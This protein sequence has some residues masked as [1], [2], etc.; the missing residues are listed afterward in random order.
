MFR[1]ERLDYPPDLEASHVEDELKFAF[2]CLDQRMSELLYFA[3][4]TETW[5]DEPGHAQ[6]FDANL[7]AK[8][9]CKVDSSKIW[10]DVFPTITGGSI[11]VMRVRLGRK[12]WVVLP[13]YVLLHLAGW[14]VQFSEERMMDNKLNTSLAGN[15][16]SAYHFGPVFMS[17]MAEFPNM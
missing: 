11:I 3:E 10:S 12:R 9:L 1:E 6:Y 16:F 7:S 5:N 8:Y 17:M 15:C 13:G 2:S 4:M 14:P